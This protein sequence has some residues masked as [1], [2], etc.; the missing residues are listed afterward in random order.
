MKV[1]RVLSKEIVKTFVEFR[2]SIWRQKE[3]KGAYRTLNVELVEIDGRRDALIQLR[4]GNRYFSILAL[5]FMKSIVVYDIDEFNPNYYE[6]LLDTCSIHDDYLLPEIFE[7]IGTHET[8]EFDDEIVRT[9]IIKN[10]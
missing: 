1:D 2:Q 10:I 8:Q 9:L 6:R 5:D 3:I 4:K 7:V